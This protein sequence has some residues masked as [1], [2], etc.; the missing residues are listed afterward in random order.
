MADGLS[1]RR[2]LLW[3]GM[4]GSVVVPLAFLDQV[5]RFALLPQILSLQLVGLAGLIVW[6]FASR[7]TWRNSRLLLPVVIFFTLETLSVLVA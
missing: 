2:P 4:A 3:V 5:N 7:G 6:V 1:N